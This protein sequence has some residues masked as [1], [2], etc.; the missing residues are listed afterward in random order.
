MT[1][2]VD[3]VKDELAA[4]FPSVDPATV[5]D[6]ASEFLAILENCADA[7]TKALFRNLVACEGE[8]C[9]R[10]TTFAWDGLCTA[11]HRAQRLAERDA[12]AIEATHG[13]ELPAGVRVRRGT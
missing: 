7:E 4:G 1:H 12:A 2:V 8:G 13:P 5:A 3:A 9:L 10:V 6:I 11:C